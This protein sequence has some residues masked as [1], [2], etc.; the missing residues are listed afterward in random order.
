MTGALCIHFYGSLFFLPYIDR[1]NSLVGRMQQHIPSF[2]GVKFTD[3]N[4]MDF[5]LCVYEFKDLQFFYG[6]D[7]VCVFFVLFFST[8]SYS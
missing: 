4:L 5:S 2:R 6:V 3:V 8:F 1:M 7:E